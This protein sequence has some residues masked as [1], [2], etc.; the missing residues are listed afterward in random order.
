MS[1]RTQFLKALKAG[2]SLS[3]I[4]LIPYMIRQHSRAGQLYHKVM[5]SCWCAIRRGRSPRGPPADH[6]LTNELSI[7]LV[8]GEIIIGYVPKDRNHDRD[9]N[10][11]TVEI[12]SDLTQLSSSGILELLPCENASN[13]E[14]IN[15]A[16]VGFQQ[17]ARSFGQL[18]SANFN[19]THSRRHLFESRQSE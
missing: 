1:I 7:K 2:L 15:L 16:K 9:E 18:S 14:T 6:P 10:P 19:A 3:S 4:D 13:S 8:L 17:K 12:P 5:F 11:K